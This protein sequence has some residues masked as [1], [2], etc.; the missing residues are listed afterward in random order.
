MATKTRWMIASMLVVL[1]VLTG[2]LPA[3]AHR[4]LP[5]AAPLGP[6]PATPSA[7][8]FGAPVPTAG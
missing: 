8:G 4:G 3:A 2:M 5:P 1:L 7:W 6:Q